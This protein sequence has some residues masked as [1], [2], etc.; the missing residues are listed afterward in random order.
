MIRSLTLP[1][2]IAIA[3]ALAGCTPKVAHAE[4]EPPTLQQLSND[5]QTLAAGISPAVVKVSA[6]RYSATAGGSS[7]SLISQ[8]RATGSGAVL[9]QDGYIVTNWHVVEGAHSISVRLPPS[10]ASLAGR[11]SVV[12]PR[13]EYVH[14]E[15]IGHDAETDLAL[16]KVD[17]EGLPF[18]PLGDSEDI[19][20]GEFVLAFGS[21]YG[22]D[23]SVSLGVV[24][25]ANRQ[26]EPE[27]P[28]V[29]IQT[30]APINPG[31]SGGPLVN[32]RG[33]LVGINTF[34]IS[35]AGGSD[36]IGFAV[37]SNIVSTVVEQLRASGR[38]HRGLIGVKVQTITPNMADGLGLPEGHGVVVAD[39]HPQGPAAASG[40]LPG[41]LVVS[42]DG[43]P[44]ENARQ[45][46]LAVYQRPTGSK[47]KLVVLRDGKTK[48]FSV[49]VMEQPGDSQSLKT[50]ADPTKNV[51][52]RLGILGITLDEPLAR[53]LGGVRSMAGVVVAS[54]APDADL[55]GNGLRPGDIIYGVNGQRAANFEALALLVSN[56][57]AG[58]PLVVQIVRE[59]QMM[60]VVISGQ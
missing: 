17:V 30:D 7:T 27:S 9:T 41:D 55:D 43:R 39:V 49:E 10:K 35:G 34:I 21:P 14:A 58:R 60:Y 48:A 23:G 8:G 24:S 4:P 26:V 13:G 32:V 45:F 1:T 2:A 25:A 53:M 3:I 6:T 40:V 5:V 22:L 29:Y 36:G 18:I 50:Q 38:V 47:T 12:V 31:N 19:Q 59:Q 11:R 42:L 46:N 37:P 57:A 54:A 52:R 56:V 33:E 44:M 20:P 28:M 16:L 15:L 51:I